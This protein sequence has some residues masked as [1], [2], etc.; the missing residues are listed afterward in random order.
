MKTTLSKIITPKVACL[1]IILAA[2]NLASAQDSSVTTTTTTAGTVREFTPD[3]FTVSTTSSPAPVRYTYSKSTTYVDEN[4]NPVAME[5]VRSGAPVTVYY[6]RDGDQMRATKVVVRKSVDTSS[7]GS[8]VSRETTTTTSSQ[9]T[10]S[11]FNPDS[12][13][14]KSDTS[15]SPVNYTFTKTTTYVDQNGNPVSV[16]T[17]KSG[18]PVTVY[19]DRNGDQ[20]VATRVVVQNTDPNATVIQHTKTTTTTTETTPNP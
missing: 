3:A 4:G 13:A 18:M 9:G 7:D 5:T 16:D 1:G 6:D 19:Y 2:A 14:L 15:P 8:S 17:V 12:I 20:M 11:A 10:I